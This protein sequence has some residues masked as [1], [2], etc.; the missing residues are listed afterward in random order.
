MAEIAPTIIEGEAKTFIA[1][2]SLGVGDSGLPVRYAGAAADPLL[3][4]VEGTLTLRD[5]QRIV[6]A[7]LAGQVTG[8]GTGTETF[9]GQGGED[10]VVS[11]V[12]ASGNRSNVDLDAT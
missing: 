3:G 6:L 9:K 11:T 7:V 4:V 1:S 10:R 12:D 2:W 5:V 8:A